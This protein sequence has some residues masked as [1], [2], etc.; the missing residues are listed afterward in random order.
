M[1]S[2]NTPDRT[3]AV[4]SHPPRPDVSVIVVT[5]N[6]ASLLRQSLEALSRLICAGRWDAIVVDNS[7]TDETRA[8]VL[9]AAE[10][11]P[12]PLQYVF[13][14]TPGKYRAL[15][16]GIRA[17][18]GRYI[19]ATD[20]DAY[21]EPDWLQRIVEGFDEFDC[22]FVG[23]PVYPRWTGRR[24]AWVDARDAITGKVLGLQDHG[25]KVL[26]YGI[27]LPSWPLGVNVAYRREVFDHVGLFDPRLGRI[28]GTLRNQSQREWHLRARAAGLRGMYLPRV[29]VY[30]TVLP[31]RLTRRY[32]QRWFYWHGISRAIMYGS[33]GVH[34][35]EP[36]SGAR[37]EGEHHFL[38]VPSSLW[39][40]AARS[41]LSA[42]KRWLLGRFNDAVRY[43][44]QLC[45]C[46]GVVR[47]RFRDTVM[48]PRPRAARP[49]DR[50]E[51]DRAFARGSDG[52]PSSS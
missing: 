25:A 51:T 15:N 50:H 42:G 21:P 9:A 2:G 10:R 3:A 38:G 34:I 52:V 43:E 13:E 36:E 41:S 1:A 6:R 26:E 47:Q 20:D 46:A 39:R 30:H 7:S 8:V 31:E 12:V 49:S 11:F 14:G 27:D 17:A 16:V 23:G 40:A 45:F 22:D 44:L 29:V 18:A 33:R 24:P 48:T 4:S 37:H 32:F 5:H 19:A 28:A 35:L